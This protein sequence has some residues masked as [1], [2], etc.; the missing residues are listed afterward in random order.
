MFTRK[1]TIIPLHFDTNPTQMLIFLGQDKGLSSTSPLHKKAK[2]WKLGHTLAG[3]FSCPGLSLVVEICQLSGVLAAIVR[4]NELSWTGGGYTQA[5]GDT[6]WK[7]RWRLNPQRGLFIVIHCITIWLSWQ[8]R[9]AC[10][11]KQSG[12]NQIKATANDQCLQQ[13]EHLRRTE[14]PS[15]K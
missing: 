12:C 7:V 2:Y 15:L 4:A 5:E 6:C 11:Q 3:I 9:S 1:N 13:G 8:I 14:E 10:N